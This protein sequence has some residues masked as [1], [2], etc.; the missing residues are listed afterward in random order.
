MQPF[1]LLSDNRYSS[2]DPRFA[3]NYAGGG[4]SGQTPTNADAIGRLAYGLTN[5]GGVQD[6]AGL[7]G[8]PSVAENIKRGNNLDASLQMLA[9]LPMVGMLGTAGKATRNIAKAAKPAEA[10]AEAV[11]QGIVAYHGSPHSFDQFSLDK[12]GTGEGAQVYGHGLYFAD[13]EGVA[14]SY[15]DTL[16]GNNSWKYEGRVPDGD[17]PHPVANAISF[18]GD[19]IDGET[20]SDLISRRSKELRDLANQ[21]RNSGRMMDASSANMY[22]SA[23]SNIE[24]LDPNSLSHAGSMY[25]VKINADPEHFLD[26]DRPLSEQSEAVKQALSSD[27]RANDD[28]YGSAKEY[29]NALV[30]RHSQ[31]APLHLSADA[32]ENWA[33]PVVSKDLLDKGIPGIKYLDQGSRTSNN[34]NELRGTISILTGAINRNPGDKYLWQQLEQAENELKQAEKGLSRNYVV[35]DDSLIDILKK[36]GLVGLLGGGMAVNANQQQSQPGL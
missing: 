22:D 24:K 16:T 14:K 34:V 3:L 7:L 26:W 9:A 18:L 36:Y 1:G 17:T 27:R 5:L 4:V 2:D 21:K 11:P 6:A 8:G 20:F 30:G 35:F 10:I 23:A 15:R 13:N 28:F 19:K 31:D 25:Q 29:Y 33:A 32:S 12:I